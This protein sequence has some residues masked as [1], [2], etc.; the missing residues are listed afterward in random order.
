MLY[1]WLIVA[2]YLCSMLVGIDVAEAANRATSVEVDQKTHQARAPYIDFEHLRDPFASYL[3]T[4]AM[5][6]QRLLKTQEYKLANRKREPLE[7]F[8]L[9]TL[10]L[11]GIYQMGDRHVAMVQDSQGK[12]YMVKQGSYMGKKSGR[13]EKIDS[14]TIYVVEKILNIEGQIIDQ[15]V[16]LTLKEV[17]D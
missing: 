1:K 15:Q 10:L 6:G 7:V 4:I 13:I 8:D 17:N 16:T 11:V 14:D 9:N 3:V 12:G 2:S 5:R